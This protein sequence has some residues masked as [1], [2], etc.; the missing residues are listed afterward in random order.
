MTGFSFGVRDDGQSAGKSVARVYEFGRVEVGEFGVEGGEDPGDARPG[1]GAEGEA[2]VLGVEVFDDRAAWRPAGDD[3]GR[4]VESGFAGALPGGGG[5][6]AIVTAHDEVSEVVVGRLART[7][8]V[9]RGAE[10][11][12]IDTVHSP[13]VVSEVVGDQVPPAGPDDQM[14]GLDAAGGQEVVVAG[15][16]A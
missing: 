5:V 2:A 9:C 11:E 15:F 1:P 6:A 16:G 7:E 3:A 10:A 12:P 4:Q 14:V 13:L 8:A